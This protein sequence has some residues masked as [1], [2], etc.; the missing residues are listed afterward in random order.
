MY[1]EAGHWHGD[2]L[3]DRMTGS[4]RLPVLTTGSFPVAR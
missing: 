1:F 3:E 4:D 2:F